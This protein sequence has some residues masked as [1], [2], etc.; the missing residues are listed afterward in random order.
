MKAGWTTT[1]FWTSMATL[2]TGLATTL[3]YLTSEQSTPLVQA[4]TQ[5]AGGVLMIASVFGY[6]ISR[7]L[8]KMGQK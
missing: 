7:G 2:L 4:V 5:I 8:A 1:E 3:G 6:A